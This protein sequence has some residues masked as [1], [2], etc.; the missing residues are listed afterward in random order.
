MFLFETILFYKGAPSYYKVHLEEAGYLFEAIPIEY[1]KHIS[2]PSFSLTQTKNGLQAPSCDNQELVEQAI[3]DIQ[4]FSYLH[5]V[6]AS[7]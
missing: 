7:A 4:K 1:Y 5:K 2:F 6:A 3:E